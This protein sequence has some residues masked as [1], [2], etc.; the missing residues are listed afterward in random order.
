MGLRSEQQATF[1]KVKVLVKQTKAMGISHEELPF[2]F[3]MSVTL[4]GIC[5]A[6]GRDHQEREYPQ[7]F[8]FQF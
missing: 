5:W 6:L 1:E 2:E 4:E 3:N 7:G 8:W